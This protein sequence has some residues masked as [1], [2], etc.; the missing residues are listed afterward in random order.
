M[1]IK[2]IGFFIKSIREDKGLSQKYFERDGIVS[3]PT[4]SRMELG[5]VGSSLSSY[6]S[7]LGE[8]G[9]DVTVSK[10]TSVE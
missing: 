6:I 9:Y 8:L 1:T 4:L 10:K 3:A 5:E 2:E 7:V